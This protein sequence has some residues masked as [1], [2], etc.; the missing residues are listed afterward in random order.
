MRYCG[1]MT[2]CLALAIALAVSVC[3]AQTTQ[4][5]G[6]GDTGP[7]L[8]PVQT[9]DAAGGGDSPTISDAPPSADSPPATTQPM[10]R[11][12]KDDSLFGQWGFMII[13][14]GG[15]LLMLFWS[16]RSRRKQEAKHRDM[17]SALK[18]GD[19]I[20]TIGGIVGTVIE[21]RADEVTIKVDETNNVRMKFVRS[22]IRT[23]GDTAKKDAE[24]ENK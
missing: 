10:R 20:V 13:I 4:P 21:V 11:R 16:S 23:V 18:K 1:M 14:I 8:S 24:K 9:E 15:M 5:A 19:K 7:K 22:A 6:T 3:F 17:L 2:G 12:K